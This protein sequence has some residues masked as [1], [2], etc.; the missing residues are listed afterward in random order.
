MNRTNFEDMLSRYSPDVADIART[1]RERILAALPG[2][3][4]EADPAAG[5][6]GYGFGPGYKGLVCTL[7]LSKSGVKLGLYKG[8]QLPDPQR[9]LAGTG[10]VHRYVELRSSAAV[11]DRGIDALIE[12]AA[13]ACKARLQDG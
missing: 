6:I 3:G 11:A 10:K 5:P 7:I 13:A 4:E 2:A 9:L 8:A 1:A 12:A